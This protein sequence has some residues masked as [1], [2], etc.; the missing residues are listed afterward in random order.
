LSLV[1]HHPN[2]QQEFD[3]V[4]TVYELP[5][6]IHEALGGVSGN[7]AREIINLHT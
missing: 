6:L 1:F 3:E 5:Q 7:R 4:V 2:H